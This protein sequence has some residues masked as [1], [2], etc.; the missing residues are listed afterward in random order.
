MNMDVCAVVM[1]AGEGKRMNSKHSKVVQV[2]A[3]K[4]LVCW[5]ADA[6]REAGA[7]EQVY[8]VGFRQEEVRSALGEDVAFVLQEQQLGTGHAVMQAAPFLEGRNGCTI[9]LPGDAPMITPET[10]QAAVNMFANDAFGAVVITAEAP[11]PKGYGRLVRDGEGHVVKIVEDRDATEEEKK[12]REINSSIYCFKTPLLLSALGRIDSRNAQKEYYLTDT[13]EILI[14]DGHKVGAY[15]GD[16]NEIRGVN[17]RIELQ[18]A[19]KLLNKRVCQRHMKAGVQIIDSESTWIDPS[20]KIGCDTILYPDTILS[21]TTVIG[22]D[23]AIGPQTRIDNA[24][25]GDGTIVRSSVAT[26]CSIGKNCLIG[27][28][29]HIRPESI[30]EDNVTI[31]AFVEIKN[32]TIG[33]YTRARHLTYVGDSQVGRNVNFGCGTVT[34]NYDGLDKTACIIEDNVFIGGNSNLISPLT[35]KENAYVAAGSTITEDVPELSLAIAR[36]R[37]IVKEGWVVRKNR[38]RNERIAEKER[39]IDFG[40]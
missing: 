14:R 27:P 39:N 23:C 29:S 8:I 21:G 3:G 5:V 6:L 20:V 9:V 19:G 38:I 12:I 2:A 11:D 34:C 10:L 1:A 24:K 30:L 31:G 32:S 33:D 26:D 40:K 37:Q 28:F 17:D 18:E 13:I 7:Q 15:V 4:P 25:V 36:S 16:F 22:E 35:L